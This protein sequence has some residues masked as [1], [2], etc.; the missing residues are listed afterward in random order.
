MRPSQTTHRRLLSLALSLALAGLAA[1]G[2]EPRSD[3]TLDGSARV[4]DDEGVATVITRTRIQL[5]GKRSYRVGKEFVSFSTYTG[6][7]ESMLGRKGQYV[8]LG[9]HDGTAVWMAGVAAVVPVPKPA[10]Y[11]VGR[12]KRVDD[13]RLVFA[14]GTVLRL[15]QGV[16]VPKESRTR[17]LQAQIDPATHRVVA[18]VVS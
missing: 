17:R 14:D 13:G 2:G 9:A 15:G 7:F 16:V 6:E 8:Q 4:P 12:F 18:L 1:C 10:V 11:Y 3:L 5:D